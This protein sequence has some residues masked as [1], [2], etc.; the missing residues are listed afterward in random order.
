VCAIILFD[1]FA[2]LSF[3][4]GGMKQSYHEFADKIWEKF[5]LVK[6]EIASS[7]Q[8]HWNKI[9]VNNMLPSGKVMGDVVY[10]LRSRMFDVWKFSST[11]KDSKIQYASVE[12]TDKCVYLHFSFIYFTHLCKSQVQRL[13][14]NLV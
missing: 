12:M 5:K 11:S 10:E 4:T 9:V 6:R 7:T 3:F 1:S 2:K 14:P 13:G 8:V